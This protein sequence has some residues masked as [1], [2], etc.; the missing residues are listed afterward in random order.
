MIE[1]NLLVNTSSVLGNGVT[2]RH[3]RLALSP[4]GAHDFAPETGHSNEVTSNNTRQRDPSA[5]W[6]FQIVVLQ[7]FQDQNDHQGLERLEKASNKTQKPKFE[8][9]IACRPKERRIVQIGITGVTIF[10]K[11]Y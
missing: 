9:K 2:K 10:D 8:G 6:M 5:K 11:V 3:R 1:P 7:E 4:Q